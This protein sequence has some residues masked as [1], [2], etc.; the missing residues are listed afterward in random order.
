METLSRRALNRATLERQLLLRRVD[1]P[2]AKVIEHLV[3]LQG[4]DPDPPYFGLWSRIEGFQIEDL[5]RLLHDRQV[6]RAMLFRGTQHLL[7]ADDYVRFRP[8]FDKL[9][10]TLQNGTFRRQTEGID[11]AELARAAREIIGSGTVTRP[12]LGRALAE[13]WPGRDQVALARSAQHLL[14]VLHPPP[15]GL[16]RRRGA[17][18]FALAEHWLGRPLSKEPSVQDLIRRYLAAFGPATVSDVRAWSGLTGLKEAFEPL[19]PKLRTFRDE[20]GRELFDLPD[21]PRP[22]PDVPAPVRFLAALDNVVLSY[23]DRSRIV[24]EEQRKYAWIDATMTVD[25]FVRGLWAIKRAKKTATLD[26]RLFEPL[27]KR[28]EAEVLAE[29]ERLLRFGAAD[30]EV[31]DIR[32][33]PVGE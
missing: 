21:A 12:E 5:V 31:H 11:L 27:S 25:G 30:C 2:P 10:A 3:G 28:Q 29:G 8:L 15:D 7:T 6:V 13:R 22:D 23:H 14:P 24:T 4:Q 1:W 26:I 32:F 19:R 9:L 18:P 17:T 20:N 33:R 16:W